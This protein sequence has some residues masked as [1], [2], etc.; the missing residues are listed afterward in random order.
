MLALVMKKQTLIVETFAEQYNVRELQLIPSKRKKKF[1]KV[2]KL[3]LKVS[4]LNCYI[5]IDTIESLLL[6]KKTD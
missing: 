4:N 6:K 1:M 3:N 2:Q 5:Q